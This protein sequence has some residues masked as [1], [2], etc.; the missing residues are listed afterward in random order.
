MTT[1]PITQIA[2]ISRDDSDPD[3]I[4]DR[5]TIVDSD[6]NPIS[7][8]D[9]TDLEAVLSLAPNISGGQLQAAGVADD[10]A[11]PQGP[12]GIQG[13]PGATGAT[14]SAGATG[15]TGSTGATGA[16]GSAGSNGSTGATGATG[17]T[18]S[19]GATG[20][21]AYQG[22]FSSITNYL[23]GDI[24]SYESRFFEAPSNVSAGAF[25][26]TQWQQVGN[27]C[28]EST[29]SGTI[30]Y[31][32]GD[33]TV[34]NGEAYICTAYQ[35]APG[36]AYPTV[37]SIAGP[38]SHN[39]GT[40]QE[41][42]T[43]PS[44]T[45]GGD[46][47]VLVIETGNINQDMSSVH[48][49][50]VQ[51][52]G[53]TNPW[54][55]SQNIHGSGT[56]NSVGI[57]TKTAGGTVGSASTDIAAT[58]LT[59]DNT[60]GVVSC[61][62]GVFRAGVVD[63][64]TISASAAATV[65]MA[66]YTTTAA[67]ELIWALCAPDNY[68][69]PVTQNGS[70]TNA[71]YDPYS[72]STGLFSFTIA[73]ASAGA[74]TPTAQASWGNSHTRPT[75]AVSLGIKSPS[76]TA[77]NSGIWN[78]IAAK[79]A[80]GATGPTG[81]TGSTGA[82]GP[83]GSTKTSTMLSGAVTVV[84]NTEVKLISGKIPANSLVVGSVFNLTGLGSVGS[85]S[86]SANVHYGPLGTIADPSISNGVESSGSAGALIVKVTAICTSISGT[87]ATLAFWTEAL[88]GTYADEYVA[89]TTE[90]LT[91][92]VDNYITLGGQ[93]FGGSITMTNGYSTLS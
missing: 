61:L 30:E 20:R 46:L 12:Q 42:M 56:A 87:T 25:N 63:S 78:K 62:L 79:G 19:T 60:T 74:I 72:T 88:G 16:T 14:G 84:N 85:G 31:F 93:A 38:S 32:P 1:G 48:W 24:V 52:G 68:G 11:G 27:A 50:P 23:A 69:Y 36:I 49:T 22:A 57:W 89:G 34:E 41:T 5:L 40:G 65:Y 9:N 29:Y 66:P 39:S 77:F 45:L 83:S 90:T 26:S 91:I 76:S 81:S 64:A 28:P 75:Q 82:T 53:S 10:V 55:L 44:G 47:L 17:P 80:T 2:V 4:A 3:A 15:P 18:G 6:G 8:P 13:I 86:A 51:T 71:V 43:I 21:A 35:A 58:V 37:V 59:N 7:V 33:L 67:D 73:V 54:T 92:T 70:P